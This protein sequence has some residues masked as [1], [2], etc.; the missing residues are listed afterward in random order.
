MST[1]RR[2][3]FQAYT[4]ELDDFGPSIATYTAGVKLKVGKFVVTIENA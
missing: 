4:Y 1:I 2:I 3:T